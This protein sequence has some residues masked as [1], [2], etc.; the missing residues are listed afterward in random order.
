MRLDLPNNV[1][2][3]VSI[4]KNKLINSIKM[5]II[6]TKSNVESVKN[7]GH[8][9]YSANLYW[10]FGI[11]SFVWSVLVLFD[12]KNSG[13]YVVRNMPENRPIIT[14]FILQ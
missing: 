12:S 5:I 3:I 4:D 9:E 10:I 2:A 7:G 13:T 11:R 6:Y 8:W 1:Y 14:H